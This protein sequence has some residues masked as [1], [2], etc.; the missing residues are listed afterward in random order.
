MWT[1]RT[2][3]AQTERPGSGL[4]LLLGIWTHLDAKNG[5]DMRPLIWPAERFCIHCNKSSI[6]TSYFA[7]ARRRVHSVRELVCFT[8]FQEMPYKFSISFSPADAD[9]LDINQKIALSLSP[10]ARQSVKWSALLNIP[11]W[12]K[13]GQRKTSNP[14]PLH[15]AGLDVLE[16]VINDLLI[17]RLA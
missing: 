9:Y 6:E 1:K 14:S 10:F 12:P 13:Y 4:A 17:I 16:K 7:R 2:V 11:C 5:L 3:N 8:W 15:P